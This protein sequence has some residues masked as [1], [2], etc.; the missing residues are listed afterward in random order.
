MSSILVPND[1]DFNENE[2]LAVS[3]EF[4]KVLRA[5]LRKFGKTLRTWNAEKAYINHKRFNGYTFIVWQTASFTL[6]S[7]DFVPLV[8]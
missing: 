8:E 6:Q 5:S 7:M 4:Q 2:I 1:I 3:Y